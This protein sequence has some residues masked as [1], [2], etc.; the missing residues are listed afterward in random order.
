V[1][2]TPNSNPLDSWLN[3][4]K[5]EI[6]LDL[7]LLSS[8]ETIRQDFGPAHGARE[9]KRGKMV[10]LY[11]AKADGKAHFHGSEMLIATNVFPAGVRTGARIVRPCRGRATA[12][13]RTASSANHIRCD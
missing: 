5:D 9:S 12:G 11:L 10:E 2:S 1:D 7:E 4:G 8:P 3:P 13:P 6:P